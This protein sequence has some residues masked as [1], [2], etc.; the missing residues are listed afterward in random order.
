MKNLLVSIVLCLPMLAFNQKSAQ[1]KLVVGIVVDQMCYEYLYRYQAR[2]GENGFNKI[3]HN[4]TNCR[5]TMYNYVPTFTGPGHASIYTGTTPA[6]HGIVGNE[7]YDRNSGS[8]L[9]CVFDSTATSVGTSSAGGKCSPKNLKTYTITDQLKMTYP[10]ARVVSVSIKDRSAILPGGHLSNGSYWFDYATGKF[11]TSSF[12]KSELPQWVQDFNAKDNAEKYMKQSWNTLH[13]ISSYTASGPDDSPYEQV[14]AGKSTPTFP[15][16]LAQMNAS[17]LAAGKNNFSLFTVTPFANTYLTNFAIQ[18]MTS[19]NLGADAQTDMLCISYSTPDIAG[20]SFGM[21][22]VELED[23]YLRLDLEIARLLCQLE[24]QY[25][26]DGFVVFL[27]ADHAVVPVPQYLIDLKLPGGYTFVKEPLELL[28][29]SSA[30]K[31]GAPLVLCE[32][33]QNIYLDHKKIA[34][35]HLTIDQVAQFVSEEIRSWDGVKAVYTPSELNSAAKDQW[36]AMVIKGIHPKESGDVVFI[37][38]PGYLMKEL[39]VPAAHKGT[40]HGSAFNYDT[41]VPLL[42]YGSGIPAQE[43]FRPIEITDI[44]ATLSHILNLQRSGAMTG[45]PILELLGRKP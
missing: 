34:E 44:A 3:M 9:N 19:E 39:D 43:V 22:S 45:T 10:N 6:N 21:R 37:L 4:G 32:E 30:A 42:W 15:Y 1:P 16:D 13:E 29:T 14:L 33:N 7:W 25:G 24:K 26:K 18:A 20:H 8:V 28:K 38:E 23:M 27:T 31:F 12:Y 17:S 40:S 11:I 35:M 36:Q 2:F 5:T 41:H